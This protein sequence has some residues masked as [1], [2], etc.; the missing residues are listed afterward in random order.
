MTATATY[1]AAA[2]AF[3]LVNANSIGYAEALATYNAA[4]EAYAAYWYAKK[5]A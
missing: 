2:R 4:R 5:G 1:N 3:D